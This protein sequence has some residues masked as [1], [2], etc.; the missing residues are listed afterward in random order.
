[1][2][3]KSNKAMQA[4]FA[5]KF[6][7]ECFGNVFQAAVAA[8]YSEKN[9]KKN[10]YKLLSVPYVQQCIAEINGSVKAS[11]KPDTQARIA[12]A[13]RIKVFWSSIMDDEDE[14]TK[15]RLRASE[16]LAKASGMFNNDW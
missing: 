6:C 12:D 15:N 14:E 4:L 1:M 13:A 3:P 16:L 10:A 9:A 7:G 5:E 8:G 11:V 2:K